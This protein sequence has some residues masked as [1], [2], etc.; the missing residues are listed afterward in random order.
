MHLISILH[1]LRKKFLR[2]YSRVDQEFRNQIIKLAWSDRVSFEEIQKK[3]GLN[4]GQVIKVMRAS[5][6]P[7]SF[8]LWRKRVSGRKTKHEKLFKQDQSEKGKRKIRVSEF[9]SDGYLL[10]E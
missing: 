5:L 1:L 4:E 3:T 2:L 6:K 8:R 7:S 9:D 10:N